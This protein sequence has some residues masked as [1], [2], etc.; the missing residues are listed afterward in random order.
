MY[1]RCYGVGIQLT[2]FNQVKNPLSVV[3]SSAAG[4][5][6]ANGANDAHSTK[7]D[8]PVTTT[9]TIEISPVLQVCHGLACLVSTLHI[10]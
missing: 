1:V 2:L 3:S 5:N 6:G 7:Y 8:L 9:T 10:D 4:A